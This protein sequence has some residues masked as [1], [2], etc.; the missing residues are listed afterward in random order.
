MG[1]CNKDVAAVCKTRLCTGIIVHVLRTSSVLPPE[2]HIKRH[3]AE[4]CVP[5]PHYA[6]QII[7]VE[8]YDWIVSC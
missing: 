8:F 2:G 1:P 3:G 6:T 5:F 7:A 4:S